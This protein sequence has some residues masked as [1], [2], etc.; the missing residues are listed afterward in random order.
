MER[1]P[2]VGGERLSA[3]R[4]EAHRTCSSAPARARRGLS[5]KAGARLA[6]RC[7]VGVASRR[8]ARRKEVIVAASAIN[9]PQLLMLSGIG[10]AEQ[11]RK[12]GIDVV[13]NRP[14]VGGNLQDHLEVYVQQACTRPITLNA[15]LGLLA[16]AN[17][18]FQ[19]FALGNGLGASNHF[20]ACAFIRS[21]AGRVLP[22]PANAL[23][24][25]RRPLR[26]ARCCRGARFSGACRADALSLA[27]LSAAR[28]TRPAEGAGNP[29]QL[30]ERRGGL[31]RFPRGDPTYARD[32]RP[33]LLRRFSR[34][35]ACARQSARNR[36]TGSTTSSA[37]TSRAPI[38]PA[39]HAAWAAWTM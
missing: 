4:L 28:V 19:W 16:R 8:S 26:R 18:G 22:R 17:I 30:Y 21:Q 3:P 39:E 33:T 38:T 36:M 1:P 24:P 14:G 15:H 9:S 6:C 5:S 35:G 27:R 11:M 13:A 12:H 23:P 29:L 31:A 7:A 25:R 32:F 20:E 34:R 37:R 2:L 10:P